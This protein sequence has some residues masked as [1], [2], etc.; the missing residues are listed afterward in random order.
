[1]TT[2]ATITPVLEPA[3]PNYAEPKKRSASKK[4][5]KTATRKASKAAAA[6]QR[7]PK[8]TGKKPRPQKEARP[9]TKKAMVLELLGRSRARRL[10]R[11]PKLPT[12]R[13]TAS[14]GSL[15]GT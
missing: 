2:E 13:I 1:M 12:G 4:A 5:A 9:N 15:A 11:S 3:T 6:K 7:V 8:T 14:E 10:L